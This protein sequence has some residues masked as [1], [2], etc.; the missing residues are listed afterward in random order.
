LVPVLTLVFGYILLNQTITG[1]EGVAFALMLLGAGVVSF[2][3]TSGR[4]QWAKGVRW[5]LIAVIFWAVMFL[6]ADYALMRMSYGTFIVLDTF[7]YFLA[8]LPLLVF[9]SSRKQIAEGVRTAARTKYGWFSLNEVFDLLGQM[10][11]KKSLAIA[12]A[13]GLVNVAMQVQSLYSVLIG[14]ALT[15]VVPQYIK[16]DMSFR[17]IGQKS[18]GAI[19]MVV[20][21]ALLFM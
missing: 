21:V 19:V 2:E 9:A 15:L 14:I 18:L 4:V 8:G 12:P 17:H 7:G 5:V 11:I 1:T 20:G 10:T 16:E 3:S 13:V 6:V